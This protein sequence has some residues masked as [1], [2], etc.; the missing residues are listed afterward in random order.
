MKILKY[1]LLII[2]SLSSCVNSMNN[3]RPLEK[4]DEL[5]SEKEFVELLY[6][7]QLLEGARTGTTVLG[8]SI[9][10]NKF[11]AVLYD[12]FEVNKNQVRNSFK[13]YHSNPKEMSQYYQW[14]IDSLRQKVY[15]LNGP[16]DK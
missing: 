11:Y 6:Q 5:I 12:K 9:E 2:I 1:S 14:I 7:I 15:E 4:P 16:L 10:L 3:E 13:Y 8:D